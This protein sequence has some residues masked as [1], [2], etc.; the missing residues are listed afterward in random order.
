MPRS[1][2]LVA[3]VAVLLALACGPARPQSP[4]SPPGVASGATLP[5]GSLLYELFARGQRAEAQTLYGYLHELHPT[6]VH[7]LLLW[8]KVAG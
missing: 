3:P 7:D 6:I 8:A 2:R 5:A 4:P 1:H